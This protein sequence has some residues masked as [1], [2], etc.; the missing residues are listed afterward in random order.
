MPLDRITDVRCYVFEVRPAVDIPGYAVAVIDNLQE[1][2]ALVTKSRNN[3]MFGAGIDTIFDEFG[4]GLQRIIL[5]CSYD[6]DR[7]PVAADPQ[8]AG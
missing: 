8:L 5:G 1:T 4:D 3:D 6:V 7:A 2:I